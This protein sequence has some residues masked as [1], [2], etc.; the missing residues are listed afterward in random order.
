MVIVGGFLL[1][2]FGLLVARLSA[3]APPGTAAGRVTLV[4]IPVWLVAAAVNMW[5]GMHFAGYSAQAE[6]PV[7]LLVFSVPAVAAIVIWWKSSRGR[8]GP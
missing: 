7:F 2:G 6:L 8:S 5:V 1:L 4:F 3:G